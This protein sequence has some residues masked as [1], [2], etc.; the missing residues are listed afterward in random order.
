[1][2]FEWYVLNYNFNARK[3]EM[4][5]IFNNWTL[6]DAVEKEVKKYLRAP[7]KYVYEDH[8]GNNKITGFEAFCKELENLIMWQ[9]WAR[10]EYEISVGDLFEK[11]MSKL[12]KWDCYM[13]CKPNI[14]AIAYTVIRQYK[15]QI[16]K[17]KNNTC[18]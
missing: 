1:M 18:I 17:I 6:N 7:S 10:A 13:Q 12:E 9:E 3:V 15:E 8:W 14:E 5:N 2:K 4:F 16:K 11:D